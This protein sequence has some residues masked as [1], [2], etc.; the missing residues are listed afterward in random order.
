MTRNGSEVAYVRI[1]TNWEC[2]KSSTDGPPMRARI[3]GR[4]TPLSQNHQGLEMIEIPHRTIPNNI[5]CCPV[6][7]NL[8]ISSKNSLTIYKFVTLTHDI[9]K[10]CF[11]D[12]EQLSV[13]F[14]LSFIPTRM[15]IVEDMIAVQN[16]EFLHVFKVKSNIPTIN[17]SDKEFSIDDFGKY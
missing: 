15:Q 4:V 11:I 2:L 12:F 17:L 8:M 1:Y 3:A 7:G 10:I 13:D 16:D 6:S 14:Q 5:A 9:S